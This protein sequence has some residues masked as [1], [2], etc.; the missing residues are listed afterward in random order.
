MYCGAVCISSL[1]FVSSPLSLLLFLRPVLPLHP[2]PP[3]HPS[4]QNPDSYEGQKLMRC[5]AAHIGSWL[6]SL[7]R[8]NLATPDGSKRQALLGASAQ[9]GLL[10]LSPFWD[11]NMFKRMTSLYVSDL[12]VYIIGCTAVVI[13]VAHGVSQC[14]QLPNLGQHW[15]WSQTS[16]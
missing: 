1:V 7:S 5:G 4:S 15:V 11:D 16:P 13:P 10:L 6:T 9:G 14:Q 2:T 3:T 12:S 8:M